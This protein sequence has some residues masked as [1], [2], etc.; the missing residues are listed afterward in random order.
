[1]HPSPLISNF[2]KKKTIVNWMGAYQVTL[3]PTQAYLKTPPL[4]LHSHYSFEF[5]GI[6]ELSFFGGFGKLFVGMFEGVLGQIWR[7]G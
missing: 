5:L 1:M 3:R 4:L 7:A 6:I 2:L